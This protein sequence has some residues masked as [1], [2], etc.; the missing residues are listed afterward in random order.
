M[1]PAALGGQ[2]R[3]ESPFAGINGTVAIGSVL[4][5]RHIAIILTSAGFRQGRT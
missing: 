3:A 1:K 2:I 5:A 4:Y